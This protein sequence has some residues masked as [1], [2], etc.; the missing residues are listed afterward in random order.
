MAAGRDPEL[1]ADRLWQS[2]ATAVELGSSV[3]RASFPTPD[4]ARLVAAELPGARVVEVDP[5]WR[6]AWRAHAGPVEVGAGLVVVPAWRD[7]Q[8]PSGRLVLRIDPGD[9]FGSGSHPSTRLVLGALERRPPAPGTVVLD[10]GSGSGILSVAAA[11]LGAGSVVAVDIDPAAVRATEVNAAANGVADRVHA[12][13]TPVAELADQA[14]SGGP[15]DLA[16]VN[17]TAGVH[18]ELGPAVVGLVRPGGRIL[19]AGLLEGQWRHV[20]RA[21]HPAQMVDR[22]VLDGWEGFELIAPTEKGR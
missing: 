20:A 8:L 6:D 19:L 11:R 15:F 3:V 16:M 12:S 10:A 17:V 5:A 9:S 18:A 4:A 7:V 13:A 1:S 14:E 22:S 2:G 21:Y